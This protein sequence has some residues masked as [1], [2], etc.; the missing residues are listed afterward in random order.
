MTEKMLAPCYLTPVEYNVLRIIQNSPDIS[1]AEMRKRLFVSAPS[2]AEIIASLTKKGYLKKERHA[3]DS[4]VYQL[5]LLPKGEIQIKMAQEVIQDTLC[6]LKLTD[7][8]LQTIAVAL[9]SL[10]LSLLQ[11]GYAK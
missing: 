6:H 10:Q 8:K 3:K 5:S 7:A 9:N 4:R 2:I 11:F 1:A